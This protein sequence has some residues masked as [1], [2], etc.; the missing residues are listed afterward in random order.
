MKIWKPKKSLLKAR[1][2]LQGE[3]RFF[4]TNPDGSIAWEDGFKNA[5]TNE[6][7][8]NLLSVYLGA[9]SQHL[10]WYMGLVNN[11][12]FST[13]A[14]ADT[15]ASHAG[16]L[17]A[18]GGGVAY[19][20]NRKTWTPA[21]VTGQVITNT[22]AVQFAI[23]ATITIYGAFLASAATGTSGTLFATGAFASPQSLVSGQTLNGFYTCSAA[24]A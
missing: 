18:A 8:D 2:T 23:T 21:A 10:T 19:T 5:I 11:A 7:L 15:L 12:S 14:A 20:G 17:E 1:A 3:W 22:T 13:F 16:W 24:N 9:G 4:A 6:G